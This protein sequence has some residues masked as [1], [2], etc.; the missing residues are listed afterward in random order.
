M[1]E[2]ALIFFFHGCRSKLPFIFPSRDFIPCLFG[3]GGG[4]YHI[5]GLRYKIARATTYPSR[6]P[7]FAILYFN[8][9]FSKKSQ[10][11]NTLAHQT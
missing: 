1:S 8:F 3:G 11:K 7:F 4:G 2:T 6:Q 9:F 5:Q 10:A